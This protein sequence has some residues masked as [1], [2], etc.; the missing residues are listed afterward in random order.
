MMGQGFGMPMQGFNPYQQ[1]VQLQ[2]P[3]QNP[4]A[5]QDA[6]L[7]SQ[8]QSAPEYQAFENARKSW[9]GSEGYKSYQQKRQD[10]VRQMQESQRQPMYGGIGGLGFNPM[11]G[12]QFGMPMQ[13][14]NPMMGQQF[15]SDHMG[16]M[17]SRGG[18]E[19]S[20]LSELQR[21][22]ARQQEYSPIM[23]LQFGMPIQRPFNP[24]GDSGMGAENAHVQS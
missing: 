16:D 9:E 6:E 4:F 2:Q 23:G 19:M 7:T 11:M 3:Q 22:L 1:H 13:G 14:F 15:S 17:M 21:G 18:P 5:A 10:L 20:R 12:P 24:F 8:M